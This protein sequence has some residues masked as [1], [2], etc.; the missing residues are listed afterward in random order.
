MLPRRIEHEEQLETIL[1]EPSARDVEAAAHVEGDVLLLGAAG[2]MGPSLARRIVRAF[3]AA[4]RPH[5]VIA[6]SRFSEAS[7]IDQLHA[8]GV[9]TRQADLLAD[10]ALEALPDAPNVIY[11][12]ARKFGSTGSPAHTW[13]ANTLLPGLVARR[14]RAS[15][16]VAFSTG[17]VYPFVPVDS[18]GATEL[19]PPDPVGEYGQS[20]LGRERMFEYASLAYG[21]RCALLRLNY[22]VE[23][24][25]GV[26][27]DLALRVQRG[28]PV[29]LTMGYV[30][31][32][33]Q[34]YA[35]SVAFRALQHCANPPF[36]LNLT[37]AETLPVRRLAGE[38]GDPRFQG[39]EASTALLSN[40]ALCHKLFGPPDVPVPVLIEWTRH[41]LANEGRLLAKPTK[42]EVR[43]GKF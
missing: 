12:A 8:W 13:A 24:R 35:N 29:D 23:L 32:V 20:A 9:E 1:S 41:W 30:N 40:A 34:G 31:L 21:T 39:A 15:R 28:E 6:V 16:I 18:G 42:F 10:G 4:G 14:Y 36:V 11:M 37:G 27:V 33:W 38:F 22:A 19:T 17:N 5:R 26:L 25:Y 7:T 43:D 2:K 3:R